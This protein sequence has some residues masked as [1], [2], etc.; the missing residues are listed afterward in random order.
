MGGQSGIRG[1]GAQGAKGMHRYVGAALLWA[2]VLAGCAGEGAE[3]AEAAGAPEPGATVP[4]GVRPGLEVLLSDSIHLLRGRTVGLITN[5]TGIDREGRSGIDLLFRHPEVRLVALF[6]PEHGIRGTA[7]AGE[8]VDSSRDTATG[9]PIHSLYGRT[10][11]PTPEMLEGI[12]LL[13][14]DIQDIGSRYYTYIYTL[15]RSMEA[16]VE[17]G[18]PLLVLDRPNPIGGTRV[19][20]PMLDPAFASFV[21]LYP[22]PV[23]HGMTPGEL[24]LLYRDAFGIAADVGVIPAEGWRRTMTFDETGLPWVAPSP[25]MRSVTT[26]LHYPGSC[27]FEGTNLSIGRGS[28]APFQQFGA[29]WLDAAA[30]VAALERWELPG[31]R[32]EAVRFTPRSP[33]DL[34]FD[35]VELPGVRW[36]LT[37]E[38]VYDPMVAGVAALV[39]ARRMSGAEWRWDTAHFD[40]LAGSDRL[41]AQIEAWAR[42][43]EPAIAELRQE[44]AAWAAARAP[45]EALR[46]R[47]LLPEYGGG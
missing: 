1:G 20:G 42:L 4:V 46:A 11:R 22:I 16:A 35:G 31:V 27:L 38:A 37:D 45:F 21:G 32:F 41:R 44:V 47:A 40:R 23:R 30:L 18:I 24:A 39:E 12:D 26:A 33:G 5:Q 25:N 28:E 2:A 36:V 17:A 14:F 6:S 29:P 13:L 19:E 34:K 43:P 9:L 8:H 3:R 15:A 7:E 10:T